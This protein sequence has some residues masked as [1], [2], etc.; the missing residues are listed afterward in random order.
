MFRGH[1]TWETAADRAHSFGDICTVK[2]RQAT[3]REMSS[4]TTEKAKKKK[5]GEEEEHVRVAEQTTALQKAKVLEALQ[6]DL[7]I[8][9]VVHW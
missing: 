5:D 7:E 4:C 1:R 8:P 6:Y 2:G 9:C 3:A